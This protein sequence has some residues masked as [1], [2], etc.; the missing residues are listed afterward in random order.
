MLCLMSSLMSSQ[1]SFGMS[2]H[3]SEMDPSIVECSVIVRCCLELDVD[4]KLKFDSG[5]LN[6][7]LFIQRGVLTIENLITY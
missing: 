4:G 3:H 7:S 5:V 1:L 2:C 6:M